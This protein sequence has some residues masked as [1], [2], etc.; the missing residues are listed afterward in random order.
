[1]A[2]FM[3]KTHTPINTS[4][5]AKFV[6][7]ASVAFAIGRKLLK[8]TRKS[9]RATKPANGCTLEA[10]HQA[11]SKGITFRAARQELQSS[12][13]ERVREVNT[14]AKRDRV[15]LLEVALNSLKPVFLPR[16]K[17]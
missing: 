8:G 9:R 17:V 3:T 14:N 2:L 11:C 1:M 15:P 5:L 12:V 13:T 16:A 4:L 6:I 10:F 7:A